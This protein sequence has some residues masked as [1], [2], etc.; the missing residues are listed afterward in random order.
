[1]LDCLQ[2]LQSIDIFVYPSKNEI[3]GIAVFEALMC[4]CSVIVGDDSGCGEWIKKADA[5]ILIPHGQ[6]QKIETAIRWSLDIKNQDT[7]LMQK[8]NGV[9][10]IKENLLYSSVAMKYIEEYKNICNSHV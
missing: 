10:F 8:E 5:G 2:F 1:M 3:F 4:G 6:P 9:R 7:I